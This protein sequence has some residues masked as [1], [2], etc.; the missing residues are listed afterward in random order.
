[1]QYIYQHQLLHNFKTIYRTIYKDEY[2]LPYKVEREKNAHDSIHNQHTL[3]YA[4]PILYSKRKQFLN[5]KQMFRF[6][7]Y[8]SHNENK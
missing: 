2:Y 8:P 5:S 7:A 4:K 3:N 6:T 1:M